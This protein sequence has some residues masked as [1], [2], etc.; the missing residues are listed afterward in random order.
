M[1]LKTEPAIAMK[2]QFTLRFHTTFGESLWICGNHAAL[3]NDDPGK[4]LLMDY[5]DSESW[6]ISIDAKEWSKDGLR[7]KYYLKSKEGEWIG[8]WGDDRMISR[9]PR[10]MNSVHLIDIWNHAGEYENAFFTAPFQN[11]LLKDNYPKTKPKAPRKYTH[12]FKVKAPL[13]QK[14]EVVCVLGNSEA[15]GNWAEEK[16]LQLCK[17][18]DWWIGYADLGSDHF[19]LVYKYGTY[20]T[21]DKEFRGY[22]SGDNRIIHGD[23]LDP[24]KLTVIHDG[25]IHAVNNTWKGTGVAIPVFSLRSKNS[26]GVGEFADIKLLVEWAKET[27][28][29]LIQLLPV[30]DTIAT[31]TW[32]DSYPYAA[33]SA[34]ALHPLYINLAAVAGKASA[35]KLTPLKKK[36]AATQ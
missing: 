23:N 29:K 35:A 32:T 22:E 4:A 7:Y 18:G 17:E 30:N 6:Q 3:G 31:N 21:K 9:L 12:L 5:L 36:T 11:V 1:A 27:S 15:L 19:P 10:Q 16:P 33:I 14:N 28:L 24:Q 8:E 2:L 26:F 13:L 34:F 25:F 20:H